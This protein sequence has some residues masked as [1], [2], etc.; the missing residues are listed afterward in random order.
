MM[1][2]FAA[3]LAVCCFTALAVAPAAKPAAKKASTKKRPAARSSVPKPPPTTAEQRAIATSSVHN[4]ID[5]SVELGIQNASAMVPFYEMLYRLETTPGAEPVRVLQF[6]DSHTA[7]DDWTAVIRARFQQKF[8][9]GGPGFT[10]AGHPYLG[11]RRYD[12]K[13]AMTRGW[14]PVGLLAREG[15]GWYGLAGVGL[16]AKLAGQAISLEAEGTSVEVFY[17]RQP[18]GGRITLS[19]NGV[20]IETIPTDDETGPGYFRHELPAGPHSLSLRTEDN[21]PVRV[22]GWVLEKPHGI[23]WET[24]GVNGAQA[25]LLLLQQGSLLRNHIARRNPALVILAYGTN[26]A[27]RPDWTVESYKATLHRVITLV[28]EAA[29]SASILIVGAPDQM[30]RSRRRIVPL[31][32][33]DRI[34]TAQRDA[35]LSYGC[36]FW[37]LR[38]AMGG[39]QSMKQWVQAGMA[40]GDFVHFTSPGYRLL[41]DALFELL[42]GQYGVFQSVRKQL[43]GTSENGP[44]STT[45]SDHS[46]RN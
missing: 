13:G 32:G 27:R 20:P 30:L 23:T 7:S 36:G 43:I 19:E 38:T 4:R 10:Q 24:L 42:T 16:D 18:G 21:L 11:Y 25:D 39:P 26:E 15:D 41:G 14:K 1:K 31:D 17:L 37:N 34:L 45:H 46:G 28:R 2:F 6:G 22:F 33:I 44:Q 5:S 8:G 35:A 29:P 12:S 9:D 40:Q 3:L